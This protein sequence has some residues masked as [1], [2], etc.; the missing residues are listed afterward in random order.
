M[1]KGEALIR[2]QESQRMVNGVWVFD[3]LEP[4]EPFAT[5]AEAFE[6]YGRKLDEYWLSKIELHKKSKFTK[7]DIL[8]ILKGRYLN[9]EQ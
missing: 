3:E 5:K 8:K 1:T 6:Y 2:Q 7:Q 9:G 4:Y